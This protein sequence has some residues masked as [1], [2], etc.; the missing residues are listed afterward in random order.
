MIGNIT[1]DEYNKLYKKYNKYIK[2][3]KKY[4]DNHDIMLTNSEYN[5]VVSK[6]SDG[7]TFNMLYWGLVFYIE[8]G[9]EM[10][11]VRRWETDIRGA[12]GTQLFTG[13]NA[14]GVVEK[15]TNGEFDHI[16]HW[17]RKFYFAKHDEA[18]KSI[19]TETPFCYSFAINQGEHYKSSEYPNIKWI[20]FDEFIT[21]YSYLNDEFILWMNLLSTIIRHRD[22]IIINMLANTVDIACPYFEEMGLMSTIDQLEIGEIRTYTI[23]KDRDLRV[24]VERSGGNTRPKTS[25]K[26]FAFENS[27]LNMITNGAWEFDI[28]PHIKDSHTKDNIV[29]IYFIEFNTRVYQCEIVNKDGCMYT[30]IHVKTSKIWNENKELIFRLE[31]DTRPN[32]RINLL[33][34]IDRLGEKIA[35]F[36]N[37]NMVFYQSNEVGQ[38]IENYLKRMNEMK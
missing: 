30:Y 10:A 6:R 37:N 15:L 33:K 20:I 32:I 13:I 35:W 5:V 34:P 25:N 17:N 9:F 7:K 38:Q 24:A 23:G 28:F 29:F 22:G 31:H 2:P 18:G 36:F 21:K 11:Y 1:I 3:G 8:Y 27:K 4:Y 26:Y 16:V 14:S 19:R 12:N